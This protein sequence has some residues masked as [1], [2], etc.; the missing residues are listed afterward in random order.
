M[1]QILPNLHH[2]ELFHYVAKAGGITAAVRAIPYGIQQPAISGQIATLEKELGVSLFR[3]RPFALTP[4]GEELFAYLDPFFRNLPD[5][6][7][8]ISG[9]ASRRLRLGAPAAVIR[10]YLPGVLEVVRK[11]FPDLQLS[12]TDARRGTMLARL[13]DGSLDLAV[14]EL[15]GKPPSGLKCEIL[16]KLPLVLWLPPG[17][18]A[19]KSGIAG[20]AGKH[21]LIQP[22]ADTV[23]S[24]LFEAG[25][26]KR[27]LTWSANLELGTAELILEYVSKGFGIGLG[28]D[29]PKVKLPKGINSLPLHGFPDLV[30]AAMW[31]GSPGILVD[32]VLKGLRKVASSIS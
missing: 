22:P 4:A 13:E 27:G 1:S 14:I 2:L 9:L 3:R 20:L 16:T 17:M 10:D 23:M 21:P 29:V 18:V 26:R 31:R 32:A 15:E 12:L 7:S 25:Q 19:P 8:N 28:Y 24:R 30:I 5:V 11:S 6:A